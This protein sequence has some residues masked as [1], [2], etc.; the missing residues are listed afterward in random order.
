MAALSDDRSFDNAA[1]CST[2]VDCLFVLLLKHLPNVGI[3]LLSEDHFDVLVETVLHAE[4][5]S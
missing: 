1:Q 4:S 2:G 3:Y 5:A